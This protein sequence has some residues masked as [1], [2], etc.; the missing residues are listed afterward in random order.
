[1]VEFGLRR[2]LWEREIGGSNPS[3]PTISDLVYAGGIR[4]A[5]KGNEV[6]NGLERRV[7]QISSLYI[8]I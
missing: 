6:F 1:M 2:A 3:T 4:D 5:N 8:E 7:L